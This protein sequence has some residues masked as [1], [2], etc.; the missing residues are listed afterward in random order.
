VQP[1]PFDGDSTH[2]TEYKAYAIA[3]R[4]PIAAPA[5]SATRHH[6]EGTST[7]R[8]A[9]Q[10]IWLPRGP[11]PALGVLYRAFQEDGSPSTAFCPII[12]AGAPLPASG[13]KRFT[14]VVDSQGHA[15]I[16]LAAQ[17]SSGDRAEFGTA[18]LEL[19]VTDAQRCGQPVITV[20]LDVDEKSRLTVTATD[21]VSGHSSHLVF[22]GSS[23]SKGDVDEESHVA[24]S[25]PTGKHEASQAYDALGAVDHGAERQRW[26][27][28][29]SPGCQS[30]HHT[31]TTQTGSA[32]EQRWSSKAMLRQARQHS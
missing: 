32:R 30:T 15:I 13:T 5:C 29:G 11:L 7:A 28:A 6:F 26:L 8:A 20:K 18:E 2:R 27:C 19:D 14:S 22:A 1:L 12:R 16:R 31:E 24:K 10:R 4:A 3:P 17:I 9:Y 21:Q 25:S 23:I